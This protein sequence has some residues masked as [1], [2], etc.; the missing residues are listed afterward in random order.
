MDKYRRAAPFDHLPRRHRRINPTG[1]QYYYLTACSDRQSPGTRQTLDEN[2][3]ILFHNLDPTREL[4]IFE[5]H[6]GLGSVLYVSAHTLINFNRRLW[7]SLIGPT[8]FDS[9]GIE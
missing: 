5:V 4:G 2:Q 6:A 9:E 3:R 8:C 7:K 1:K